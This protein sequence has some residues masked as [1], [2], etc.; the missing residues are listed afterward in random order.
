VSLLARISQRSQEPSGISTPVESTQFQFT[1]PP[2]GS[3]RVD[4]TVLDGAS[5][6]QNKSAYPSFASN[7]ILLPA[8]ELITAKSPAPVTAGP[9]LG[10][11]N[12][13][14]MEIVGYPTKKT[15]SSSSNG[16][17]P[18]HSFNGSDD[19]NFSP[20]PPASNH[21]YTLASGE[22]NQ[23]GPPRNG[24]VRAGSAGNWG[25]LSRSSHLSNATYPNGAS[26]AGEIMPNSPWSST[27]LAVGTSRL[28]EKAWA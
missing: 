19:V 13:A 11:H 16:G 25:S 12:L 28:H 24:H 15:P 14:R 20:S 27:E 6:K 17:N 10:R 3:L 1:R 21:S 22:N 7:G 8:P 2:T 9:D 4:T 5:M 26:P 23:T 18:R